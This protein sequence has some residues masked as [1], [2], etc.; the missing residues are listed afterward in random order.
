M[1][2]VAELMA[3]GLPAAL[4]DRIGEG[5]A[6]TVAAAGSTQADATAL[7]SSFTLISTTPSSAG[8]VLKQAR[9]QPV[10]VVY[11]GGANTLKIYGNGTEKINNIAGSTGISVPTTKCAILIANS[12]QWGAVVSA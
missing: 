2:T 12:N 8:V 5:A 3:G 1:A 6:A 4:A 11:N 9:G 10:T 7:T